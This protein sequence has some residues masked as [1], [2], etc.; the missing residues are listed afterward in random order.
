[1]KKTKAAEIGMRKWYSHLDLPMV[2]DQDEEKQGNI[3]KCFDEEQDDVKEANF[4][5]KESTAE[6]KELVD[7]ITEHVTKEIQ[8]Q[9]AM[10]LWLHKAKGL[11]EPFCMTDELA[12]FMETYVAKIVHNQIAKEL[13]TIKSV[14]GSVAMDNELTGFIL[15]DQIAKGLEK[16]KNLKVETVKTSGYRYQCKLCTKSYSDVSRLVNHKCQ[17]KK[18]EPKVEPLK[19]VTHGMNG[20]GYQCKRCLKCF[21]N[22]ARLTIH[23][24]EHKPAGQRFR[25]SVCR[26]SFVSKEILG[27]HKNMHV[28]MQLGDG[29]RISFEGT[30]NPVE[31]A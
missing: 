5:A 20:D 9:I 21:N 19:T 8:K 6:H 14:T 28:D 13:Q 30:I 31:G 29:S 22:V 10:E 11:V 24:Q 26:K 27:N 23:R 2:N 15:H 18:K 7:F 4:E 1:M 17:K 12:G 16:V 25:C 3:T